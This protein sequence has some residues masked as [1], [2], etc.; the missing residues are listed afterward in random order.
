MNP[1]NQFYTEILFDKDATDALLE[2]ARVLAKAVSTT[3]GPKGRNV[4]I[5]RIGDKIVLHD[6]VEVAKAIHLQDKHQD[7]GVHILREAARK[8]V[9]SVGDG[10]TVTIIL[11]NAILQEAMKIVS[12]GE[13]PMTIRKS[14]E[15]A[16]DAVLK[17]LDSIAKPV[18]TLEEK[19][20]VATISA[21]DEQL[22]E[23]IAKTIDDMGIN[24]IVTVDESKSS[25]TVVEKQTGMQFDKGYI[26]P[27]FITDPG[28]MEATVEEPY[29]LIGDKNLSIGQHLTTFL[30]AF[31]QVSNKLV[32]IAPDVADSALQVL[33]V[34]KVRGI[35]SILAVK[36]P[37]FGE[38]QKSMLQDMC[39][40]TGATLVSEDAGMS[41]QN[42]TLE[43][44]GHADR[45]TSTVDS[46]L[47]VGGKGD[48]KLIDERVESLREALKK[49]QSPFE[50]EKLR[51]RIAKLS[52]GVAI[53]RVGG[54]TEVEMKERKERVKDS[55]LAT[56]AAI[57][58]GIVPG[59][60]IALLNAR[61]VLEDDNSL[62]G[63]ILSNALLAPFKKLVENAGY[64]A[65]E[66]MARLKNYNDITV[67]FDVNDGGFKPML[68]AGII[69]P[70]KVVSCAVRN[71]IS[72]AIAIM[73]IGCSIVPIEEKDAKVS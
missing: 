32:V 65:G 1:N 60:E 45:I 40:L 18:K 24:G 61:N 11:A 6:G 52:N 64:D 20:Q 71:S 7:M 59:G 3:L 54:D 62:G 8:T 49:E 9:D 12:A 58:E 72:V 38:K 17:Y 66:M 56:K 29:I 68:E 42:V 44:A 19:I 26:S 51:E 41:W 53:I 22:G 25:E 67:G 73:T 16:K 70:K 48:K 34:N 37:L 46:T 15:A 31:S 23:L 55:V 4:A 2:G 28:K 21:E 50:Q 39:V 63:K 13:N 35:G 5:D 69:D 33:V 57:E 10:T 14:L 47:I 43:M 27:Y 30:E 36:A